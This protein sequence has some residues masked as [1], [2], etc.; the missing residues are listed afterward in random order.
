MLCFAF[1]RRTKKSIPGKGKFLRHKWVR[2]DK[3][4]DVVPL[5]VRICDN[6]MVQ[7]ATGRIGRRFRAPRVLSWQLC[8][9]L[10]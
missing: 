10:R 6:L 1:W 8:C 9:D 3:V 2:I 4:G 7:S 5:Q